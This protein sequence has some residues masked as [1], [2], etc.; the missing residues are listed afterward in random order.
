[1]T[2]LLARLLTRSFPGKET[3]LFAES[4]LTEP[5]SSPSESEPRDYESRAFA[6]WGELLGKPAGNRILE[7]GALSSGSLAYF[8]ER[9]ALLSVMSVDLS[10]SACSLQSQLREFNP[11]EPFDGSLCWDLPNYMSMQ[12]FKVLGGWLGQH[13]RPGGAVMLCLATKIPYSDS[14]GRYVISANDRLQFN[15]AEQGSMERQHRLSTAELN[16]HWGDFEIERS[17]LLRS[18]LQEYV[19]RRRIA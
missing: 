16:R 3:S 5:E 12:D 9:G 17:F 11:D 18:G 6:T 4:G 10:E 1:M 13:M 7:L 15:V 19:L 14:P 8:A 2:N